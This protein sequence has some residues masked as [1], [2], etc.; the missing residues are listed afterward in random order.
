MAALKCA[1]RC[2][3][4]CSAGSAKTHLRAGVHQVVCKSDNYVLGSHGAVACIALLVL[5][6]LPKNRPA[7]LPGRSIVA[8]LQA[9]VQH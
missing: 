5:S 6:T 9:A 2:A 1:L 3:E 4:R 8:P 7:L